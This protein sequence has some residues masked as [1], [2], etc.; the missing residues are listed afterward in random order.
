MDN[1]E[2]VTSKLVKL[3]MKYAERPK[4]ARYIIPSIQATTKD[5]VVTK[6]NYERAKRFPHLYPYSLA[7]LRQQYANLKQLW[8]QKVMIL[9]VEAGVTTKVLPSVWRAIAQMQEI[10][11]GG[12]LAL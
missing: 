10:G 4:A 12:E 1:I 6:K 8:N 5:I 2:N 11:L 9:F 3:V 7:A